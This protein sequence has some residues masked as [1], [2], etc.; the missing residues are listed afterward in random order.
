MHQF[1][2]IVTAED[3]RHKTEKVLLIAD[4]EKDAQKQAR[5][6]YDYPVRLERFDPLLHPGWDIMR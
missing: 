5:A 2:Y 4:G 3:K 6:L 1:I